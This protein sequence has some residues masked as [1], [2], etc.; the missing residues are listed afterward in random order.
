MAGWWDKLPSRKDIEKADPG[1]FAHDEVYSYVL[2]SVLLYGFENPEE[3]I[4]FC[5]AI[6]EQDGL[7]QADWNAEDVEMIQGILAHSILH[8]KTK[9]DIQERRNMGRRGRN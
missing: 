2:L 6:A 3:I 9:L 1:H 8:L 7:P 5:D 4:A